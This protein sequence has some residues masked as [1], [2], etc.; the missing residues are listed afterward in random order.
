LHVPPPLLAVLAEPAAVLLAAADDPGP[1]P[2]AV[3]EEL[4]EQA[5]ARRDTAMAADRA[6]EAVL[7]VV[8]WLG[9]RLASGPVQTRPV[10]SW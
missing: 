3:P 9:G 8:S 7:I 6:A 5:E 10:T 1:A 4:L 2:D